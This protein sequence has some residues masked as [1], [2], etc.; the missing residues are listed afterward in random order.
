MLMLHPFC[1]VMDVKV[2]PTLKLVSA[3]KFNSIWVIVDRLTKF[4]HFIPIN[5]KH[6]AE[7]FAKVYIDHVLYLHSVLKM[8]ISNRGS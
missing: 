6:R 5:T 4:A 8:T 7:E 1:Q 2:E 3:R